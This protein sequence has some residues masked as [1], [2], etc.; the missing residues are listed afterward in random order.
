[1]NIDETPVYRQSEPRKGYVVMLARNR[2]RSVYARIPLRDRR[3]QSTL[4]ACVTNVPELQKFMPQ[5]LLTNDN[6]LTNA[7]KMQLEALP[8]PVTWIRKTKGWVTTDIFKNILTVIRRNIRV[9]RPKAEIL[10]VMDC[11]PVHTARCVFT[12]CS[13]LGLHVCLVPSG[14]TF[15]CQPL[16]SH[17][18]GV[19]KRI[20]S[21]L[22]ERRR[23]TNPLGILP[24]TE[25]VSI[26]AECINHVLTV[27]SWA[28]TFAENGIELGFRM[29]RA[30]VRDVAEL[31]L[32]LPMTPPTAAQLLVLM[33]RK[34]EDLGDLPFR[35]S[36][37]LA[38]RTPLIMPLPTAR[39]PPAPL[40]API[41]GSSSSAASSSSEPP[42]LPPP[43]DL[44]PPEAYPI[45][46]TRSG[47][48]Y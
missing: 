5:F 17:V 15:L 2:D 40:A 25:W 27:R 31:A 42:P 13:L 34:R 26:V 43:A 21:E 7:E 39:L 28:H 6:N 33:G 45:R 23:G 3:G 18:F 30:R 9:H 29:L 4:L 8:S 1:M 46:R 16:D 20:L 38:E 35:T 48:F 37:R 41:A 44:P 32:P 36:K 24:S 10:V 47:A 19:F 12:H 22:Q 14:M 11:A